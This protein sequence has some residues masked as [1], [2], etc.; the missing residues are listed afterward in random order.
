MAPAAEATADPAAA[1][2]LAGL[3]VIAEP[4]ATED[5]GELAAAAEEAE[6]LT[7]PAAELSEVAAV[8]DALLQ[9]DATKA[10][11]MVAIPRPMARARVGLNDRMSSPCGHEGW[12]GVRLGDRSPDWRKLTTPRPERQGILGAEIDAIAPGYC[13]ADSYRWGRL[14]S[15]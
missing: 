5:P 7:A 13:P 12:E 2:E 1:P 15:D 4:A 11:V 10:S 3:D 14:G 6:A 9:A 8:V